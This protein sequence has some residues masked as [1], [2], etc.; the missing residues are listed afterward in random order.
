MPF[1]GK[2]TIPRDE[3][4]A[5]KEEWFDVEASGDSLEIDDDCEEVTFNISWSV[6]EILDNILQSITNE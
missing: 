4:L 3:F 2:L 5:H 6:S 1:I